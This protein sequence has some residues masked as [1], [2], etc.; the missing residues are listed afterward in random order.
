VGLT[1][2]FFVGGRFDDLMRT[3]KST[4]EDRRSPKARAA[5]ARPRPLGSLTPLT[6]EIEA[7]LA[8]IATGAGCELLH[9]EWKGGVLRLILDLPAPPAAEG[10]RALRSAQDLAHRE[11]A[12]QPASRE[13]AARDDGAQEAGVSLGDCEH[14]ARQA[15]ALLDVLD[16][17]NGRYTLEVSSPG[18]DRQLYRPADYQRFLGR[19]ARVTFESDA[20][21]TPATPA[22]TAEARRRR[23]VVARLADFR[24]P[25]D[26]AG[27]GGEVTLI[28]DKTGE[29]LELRLEDVRLARL[30]VELATAPPSRPSSGRAGTD[31][32][33]KRQ[34]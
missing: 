5:G 16:F 23:T 25:G 34:A 11:P 3:R 1:P 31:G 6:P 20:A 19:L 24:A 26:G 30:E 10:A 4:A 17:G 14:V 12:E 2:T 8:A 33:I 15:S 27:G 28:D 18:L 7:E 13:D 29:R 22:D 32:R 9:A 21:A